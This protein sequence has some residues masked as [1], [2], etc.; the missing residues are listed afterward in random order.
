[1]T[2]VGH[3]FDRVVPMEGG[4]NFR[5]IGGYRTRDG[6][7]VTRGLVYRS[8]TMSELSDADHILLDSLGLQLV[9]DLRS[10]GERSRRPSRLPDV[11][12]FEI[13]ARDHDMSAG[14]LM[15][16][17]HLPDTSAEHVRGVMIE[18]YRHLPYEQAPS[19]RALFRHIADGALP[20][21][22][23]CAAGKDRTGIAAALLLDFLG[24]ARA[25]VIEDY[26]LT[27]RFFS[28]GCELV[29]KDPIG[30]RLAG[31]DPHIWE[32]MMRADTAYLETMFFTIEQQHGSSEAFLRDELGLDDAALESIRSRLL[33]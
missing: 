11:V 21:V 15:R 32:P 26:C 31:V 4:H 24:V 17:V 30:N 13:W 14:D 25:D 22:F 12:T 10:T 1:M 5:D 23:H 18:A 33:V 9:C 27:D 3:D 6:R 8:G 29:A 28:R 16:I 19:Y 7:H 20:L 2:D